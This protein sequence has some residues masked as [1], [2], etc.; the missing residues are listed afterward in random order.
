M[1]RV[2]APTAQV[3]QGMCRSATHDDSATSVALWPACGPRPGSCRT[4]AQNT[5]SCAHAGLRFSTSPLPPDCGP[6]SIFYGK[7]RGDLSY[8]AHRG[9]IPSVLAYYS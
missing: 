2:Q 5:H 8:I 7:V 4:A 1:P 9:V 6:S 3:G